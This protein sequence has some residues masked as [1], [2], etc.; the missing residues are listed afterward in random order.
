[1]S[2]DSMATGFRALGYGETNSLILACLMGAEPVISDTI[3]RRTG[4]PEGTVRKGLQDMLRR[5][6][7]VE[8]TKGLYRISPRFAS[9]AGSRMRTYTERFEDK[10]LESV[11]R[12]RFEIEEEITTAF[13]ELGYSVQKR[14]PRYELFM[15][16]KKPFDIT[17]SFIVERSYR[18]GV[19][20]V[21]SDLSEAISRSS[22][23][24]ASI[25]LRES[26][27]YLR[28]HR[29]L[30]AFFFLESSQTDR[31]AYKRLVAGLKRVHRRTRDDF[32]VFLCEPGSDVRDFISSSVRDVK[33]RTDLVRAQLTNIEVLSNRN[34]EF[35]IQ[36]AM[37]IS[38]LNSLVSGQFMPIHR[39]PTKR[40]REILAP[41]KSVVDREAR[42]LEIFER[43]FTEDRTRHQNVID[44]FERR[45]ALPTMEVL[46]YNLQQ[47]A[48]VN[49]KFEPI[50]HELQYLN[51][52]ILL[53]YV[54]GK[55]L[56]SINPFI[57]TE[58]NTLESFTIDQENVKRRVKKFFADL[59][60]TESGLLL[61]VGKAG[62]GKTHLLHHIVSPSA[63]E[64]GLWPVYVDCPRKYDLVTGLLDEI[65]KPGNF[66]RSLSDYILSLSREGVST[67]EEFVSVIRRVNSLLESTQYRGLLLILDELENS[68]PYTFSSS[69]AR[70]STDMEPPL[71]LAQ[72]KKLLSADYGS[73]TGFLVSFRTRILDDVRESLRLRGFKRFLVS[74]EELDLGGFRDLITERYRY[75]ECLD[76]RFSDSA[77]SKVAELVDS[78]TRHAIQYFRAL[79]ANAVRKNRKLIS[80]RTV[81]SHPRLPL[82]SY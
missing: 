19:K 24:S 48:L 50:M 3:R 14:L 6:V 23:V 59:E 21:T 20:V 75:W 9:K 81:E 15:D 43:K 62:S 57:L 42:N 44:R 53:P 54:R 38:Q 39:R 74:P 70:S 63:K 41:V 51:D 58:P 60:E 28:E 72:L 76:I 67:P 22:N 16:E 52:L 71:A 65:L 61:L 34:K 46:E 77:I 66:P 26:Q 37:L 36:S 69:G 55:V 40:E 1:M 47:F 27:N 12:D 31:K 49:S 13:Q 45:I 35:H 82:F 4:L 18:F 7:V 33:N 68:L 11:L 5:D 30:G 79:Y 8:T 25:L 10:L 73:E 32:L 64:N 2:F 80:I 78:N 17:F 56:E 29:C